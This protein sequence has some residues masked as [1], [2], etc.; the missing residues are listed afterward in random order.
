MHLILKRDLFDPFP[1]EIF[2]TQCV[3]EMFPDRRISHKN[4]QLLEF[5][6]LKISLIRF[7]RFFLLKPLKN[8]WIKAYRVPQSQAISC[9]DLHG[10]RHKLAHV[11]VANLIHNCAMKA[12]NLAMIYDEPNQ[13]SSTQV[14]LDCN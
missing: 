3:W 10:S 2:T 6:F 4:T 13:S 5:E 7:S 8:W 1:N 14:T 11:T 12:R 9:H